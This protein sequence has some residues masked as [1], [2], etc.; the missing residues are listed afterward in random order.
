MYLGADVLCC[1]VLCCVVLCCVVLCCTALTCE[2]MYFSRGLSIRPMFRMAVLVRCSAGDSSLSSNLPL[3]LWTTHTT[4]RTHTHIKFDTCMNENGAKFKK[5]IPEW[6]V[7][8]T[9]VCRS[10]MCVLTSSCGYTV[11]LMDVGG[12]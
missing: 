9:R 1:V 5:L 11:V 2:A 3:K 4:Y 7:G 8:V 12:A 10:H 6:L